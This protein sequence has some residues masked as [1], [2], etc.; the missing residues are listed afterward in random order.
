M[1]PPWLPSERAT[2]KRERD[3][4]GKGGGIRDKIRW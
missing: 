2:E 3:S 4:G 1:R